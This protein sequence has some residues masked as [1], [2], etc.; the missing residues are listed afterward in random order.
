MLAVG[1]W[2]VVASHLATDVCMQ[3]AAFE[4]DVA[5]ALPYK[6]AVAVAAEMAGLL[7]GSSRV[8]P[9]RGGA[10]HLRDLDAVPQA[11]ACV[12]RKHPC[13]VLLAAVSTVVSSRAWLLSFTPCRNQKMQSSELELVFERLPPQRKARAE[14]TLP[15]T[16]EL[17]TNSVIWRRCMAPPAMH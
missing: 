8:K 13:L 3:T 7:E 14:A 4:P 1:R 9:R 2:T 12:I 17:F 15:Q 10:G 16:E 5:E 6:P 11:R